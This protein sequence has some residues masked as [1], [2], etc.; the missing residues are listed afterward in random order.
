MVN[1][2]PFRHNCHDIQMNRSKP[3]ASAAL[4]PT[5]KL[6]LEQSCSGS[7]TSIADS[8]RLKGF[9]ISQLKG[10]LSEINRT[11]CSPSLTN[12]EIAKICDSIANHEAPQLWQE[13]IPLPDIVIT[14]LSLEIYDLPDILRSWV[15]DQA[16]RMQVPIEFLAGPSIVTISSL[17][18]RK[19]GIRPLQRDDWTV[20]PNLWGMLIAEPGSM[21]SPALSATIKPLIKLEKKAKQIHA[22]DC[23]IANQ[24]I[25]EVQKEIEKLRTIV[26]SG[27]TK[28]LT[29]VMQA[30]KKMFELGEKNKNGSE[31]KMRRH[32]TND[33]TIEKLALLLCENPQGLLLVRD[34][35]SGWLESIHKKGREG[36]R[37]FFLET[38][39][40]DGS[41]VVDR[42]GRG[43]SYANAMCLSVFGG[44][45]PTKIRTFIDRYTGIGGD[46][47]FLSRFQIVFF[48]KQ[49]SNWKLVDRA[50]DLES[51]R[52][53][54][55][56]FEFLDNLPEPEDCVNFIRF[57]EESQIIADQWRVQL[58][59]RLLAREKCL[60]IQSHLSKYRS[61]MPSLALIFEVLETFQRE[62]S[63]PLSVS[64]NSVKKAIRWCHILETHI[65]KMYD[66]SSQHPNYGGQSLA[67][68]IE[69]GL[70]FDGQRLREI[71]RRNWAGLKT[72]EELEEAIKIL[73]E[74]HW[75]KVEVT[76]TAGGPSEMIR[77]NP[78]LKVE[79]RHGN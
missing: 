42:V 64:M 30:E 39:N 8:L 53:I 27:S 67:K 16:D 11:F 37:E 71:N 25:I 26:N 35:L 78:S 49:H 74:H 21:K 45:Q 79:V 10:V 52:Q 9:N 20:I 5:T 72:S 70:V 46:D 34:E 63:L 51:N 14:A 61:L 22:K 48:P 57:T 62:Q 15:D 4:P 56:L 59:V 66:Q 31:P 17:I 41:F 32:R 68:K 33:P 18:G 50:P 77:I 44:I 2:N 28:D 76:Q 75:V 29:S 13:P 40:G 3:L 38:W 1:I 19:L 12:N 23:Q 47:G 69:Q 65:A 36:S 7:L 58:E 60:I 24:Q 6:L 43:S 54:E 55:N 73:K